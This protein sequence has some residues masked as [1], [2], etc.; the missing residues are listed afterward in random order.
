MNKLLFY[1]TSDAQGVPRLLCDCKVCTQKDPLN[2]RTR[3]S[4]QFTLD[5]NVCLIDVSPDF[6]HQFHLYN[7]KK[8]PSTVFITHPHNDHV[9]GLGDLADLCYWNN[10]STEVVGAP[11]VISELIKRFPYLAKRKGLTFN[12]TLKW[13]SGETAITFH[14]V[15]HGFNGHSYGIVVHQ[16]QGARWAYV[17]DSFNVTKEQWEPFY[18]LDLL[19]FGTSLWKEYLQKEKRSVYDVTEA[20]EIKVKLQAKNMVFTHLSHDIDI[21]K[22]AEVLLDKNVSFAYDGREISLP[23][24]C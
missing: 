15:N 12:G 4:A 19:I 10:V 21:R 6:K 8:I 23:Y 22:H 9:A 17:S 3:P 5:G 20:M 18:H 24:L 2:Q 1:G 13:E 11:E 16:K 7:N 14:K